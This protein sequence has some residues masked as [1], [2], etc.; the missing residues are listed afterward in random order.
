MSYPQTQV[1]QRKLSFTEIGLESVA[2]CNPDTHQI[3][4]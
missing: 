2:F 4:D 3:G 1:I